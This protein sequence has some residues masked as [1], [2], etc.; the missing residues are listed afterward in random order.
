MSIS[1][2][3]SEEPVCFH[4]DYGHTQKKKKKKFILIYKYDIENKIKSYQNC[5]DQI[6]QQLSCE[7]YRDWKCILEL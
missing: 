3:I 1:N 7:K 2:L 5:T 4:I 6:S